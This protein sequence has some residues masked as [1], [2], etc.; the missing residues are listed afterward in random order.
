VVGVPDEKWGEIPVA[1]VELRDGYHL[2]EDA[3]RQHLLGQLA[4]YK[5]PKKVIYVDD[6]PRTASGKIRKADL[7]VQAAH[8][9][10]TGAAHP[11]GAR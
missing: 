3:I 5:I 7:R 2:D 1:M 4:R 8:S 9:G 10:P 11:G 6:L